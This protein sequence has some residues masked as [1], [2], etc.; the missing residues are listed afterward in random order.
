MIH[1]RGKVIPRAET[2]EAYSLLWASLIGG[3]QI[4]QRGACDRSVLTKRAAGWR[5][6]WRG[7]R[8]CWTCPDCR[9][10]RALEV[11]S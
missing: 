4:V 3:R 7:G 1:W 6:E 2:L 11:A 5:W 10:P 8:V 9:E